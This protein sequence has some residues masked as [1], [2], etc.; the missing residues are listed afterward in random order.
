MAQFLHPEWAWF[1]HHLQNTKSIKSSRY[2]TSNPSHFNFSFIWITQN[3]EEWNNKLCYRSIIIHISIRTTYQRWHNPF[4]WN[5]GITLSSVS[6][7]LNQKKPCWVP[8][9]NTIPYSLSPSNT[10]YLSIPSQSLPKLLVCVYLWFLWKSY[11]CVYFKKC[12]HNVGVMRYV[13]VS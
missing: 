13:L 3:E 9:S 6:P 10:F 2:Q 12:I 11:L 7:K 8:E 1:L 5:L 4:I